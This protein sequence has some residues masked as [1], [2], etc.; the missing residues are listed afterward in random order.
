MTNKLTVSEIIKNG[1]ELGLKNFVS[2]ILAAILYLVTFWI[3]YLNVGTTI[4]LTMLP[5]EMAKGKT[6]SPTSI[7]DSK[8]RKFMGEFFILLGL[9][10]IAVYS[11]F[12][13][14]IIPG[15]VI[16]IAFSLGVFLLID[17]QVHPLKALSLSNKL[18]YGNKWSVFLSSFVVVIALYLIAII[19]SLINETL[20]AIV[21][22]VLLLLVIPVMYGMKAYV[23]KKLV[24]ENEEWNAE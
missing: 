23:Y 3:P 19:I 18:M 24:L 8:N 1:L 4:G 11:G 17:K 13:F 6:I 15:I 2:L 9:I 22:F 12:L 10:S 14:L 5:V 7:F 21:I 20:G 16:A